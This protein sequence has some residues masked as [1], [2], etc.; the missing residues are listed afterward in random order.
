MIICDGG[1]SFWGV[2]YDPE[3]RTFSQLAFNGM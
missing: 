1:K 3:T 2:L